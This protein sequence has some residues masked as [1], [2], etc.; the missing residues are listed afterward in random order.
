MA[1]KMYDDKKQI[2]EE[3]KK[4]R[5]EDATVKCDNAV[6]AGKQGRAAKNKGLILGAGIFVFPAAWVVLGLIGMA[7]FI[8]LGPVGLGI[9]AALL[10]LWLVSTTAI[11]AVSQ[12]KIKAK[13]E[14]GIHSAREIKRREIS[15]AESDYQKEM[16]Q[17]DAWYADYEENVKK[18][19][20]QYC[21]G[22]EAPRLASK[23][24]HQYEQMI[25]TGR[26]D[27]TKKVVEVRFDYSVLCDRI[28]YLSHSV[29]DFEQ[30]RLNPLQSGL[31]CEALA[32]ALARVI[33]G[34]LKQ[35]YPNDQVKI[36]HNDAS[37]S[38]YYTG[39]NP[40]YVPKRNI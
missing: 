15:R 25:H 2:I 17:L 11:G 33:K 18:Q 26:R 13:A 19:A 35:K 7:L 1:S 31:Q 32:Q 22:T 10:V 38:L 28:I 4:K 8:N 9:L 27:T 37:V 34:S 40:N 24:E 12:H 6:S 30:E 14:S 39:V 5:I 3:R 29:I 23:M 20:D 21:G 16:K 36:S